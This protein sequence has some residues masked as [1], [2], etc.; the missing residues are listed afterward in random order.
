M[1][2]PV[3]INHLRSIGVPADFMNF[4]EMNLQHPAVAQFLSDLKKCKDDSERRHLYFHYI[5]NLFIIN[6]SVIDKFT[7]LQRINEGAKNVPHE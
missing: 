3:V 6:K 5:M 7:L 2:D 4:F 1:P